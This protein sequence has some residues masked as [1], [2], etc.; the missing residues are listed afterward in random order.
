VGGDARVDSW[1]DG[2]AYEAYVGRWSRLVATD[3][4]TWLG[5]GPQLRWLDVGAGTG[6]LSETILA[7]ADPVAVVGIDASDAYVAAARARLAGTPAQ[8][9][10]GDACA[11]RFEADFDA[12]ASGLVLNFVADPQA[13]AAGMRRAAVRGGLVAAYVWD[14]AG[15]MEF[16]RFFWDAAAAVDPAAAQFDEGPR[17]P[18]SHPDALAGLWRGVGLG[19]IETTGIQI[20]TRFTDFE[21]LWRPFLG[22]QGP[23]PAYLMSLPLAQ[24][25]AVQDELR[26]SLPVDAEGSIP[27]VARAWA[28]KGRV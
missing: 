22:G 24:R 16:M 25:A 28:V 21:D 26:A 17:F 7:A 15:R 12:A 8:F 19:D 2:S 10:Q 14:Y 13:A 4:L 27:L 1:S 20:A 23:A 6:A 5:A 11:L 9:E 18:L 3:F